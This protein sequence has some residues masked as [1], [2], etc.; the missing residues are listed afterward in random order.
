MFYL[1]IDTSNY[2]TSMAVLDSQ[3]QLVFER[4]SLLKVPQGKAGL[5]QSEAVF[6]HVREFPHIFDL[7]VDLASKLSGIGVSTRPRDVEDSYM[8]V[9]IVGHSFARVLAKSHAIPILECSHQHNHL[10][11]GFWSAGWWPQ[12]E[13]VLALHL[14]GGTSEVL[15]VEWDELPAVT[16]LGHTRDI[17]AGQFI[18]RVGVALGLE[19]PAGPHLEKLAAGAQG[20]VRLASPV[21]QMNMSFS[22]PL[23]AA[24]RLVNQVEPAELARGVEDCIAKAVEKALLKAALETGCR[25]ILLVGGVMSNARIRQRLSHRLEHAAVGLTLHF[26]APQASR[27]NAIG[28]AVLAWRKFC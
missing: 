27:D 9:F 18:D 8:P 15:L 28:C 19:F 1:G 12:A 21:N 14:S 25:H 10:A 4:R 2:T 5:R 17:N 6:Q 24:L 11:A 16:M 26:A 22:G 13:K 7:P 3:G 23:S 20:S